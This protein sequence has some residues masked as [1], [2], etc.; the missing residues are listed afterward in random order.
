MG[1]R[2]PKLTVGTGVVTEKLRGVFL[3]G[4]GPFCLGLAQEDTARGMAI[5]RVPAA[6]LAGTGHY[7]IWLLA[8][9]LLLL[10][11]GQCL[12]LP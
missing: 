7:R 8:L 6:S 11:D 1:F 3:E 5:D 4:V 12:W 9:V 2:G 10:Q